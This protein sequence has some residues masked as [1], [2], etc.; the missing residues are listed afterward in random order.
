[1]TLTTNLM[2]TLG[3]LLIVFVAYCMSDNNGIKF[4]FLSVVIVS[5]VISV[6]ALLFVGLSC[7]AYRVGIQ[8]EAAARFSRELKDD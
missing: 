8:L 1:M 5:V 6:V 7:L 4:A 3:S 2:A